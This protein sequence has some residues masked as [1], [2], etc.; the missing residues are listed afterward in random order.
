M[1][2]SILLGVGY[3]IYQSIFSRPEPPKPQTSF[4]NISLDSTKGDI[5]FIKGVPDEQSDDK[6]WFYKVGL[7]GKGGSDISGSIHIRFKNNKIYF[8]LYRGK[9]SL[10]APSLEGVHSK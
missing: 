2:L 3:Y 8:I 5:K 10:F 1:S 9:L 6:D 7:L 4:W